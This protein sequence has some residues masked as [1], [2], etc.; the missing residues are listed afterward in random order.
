MTVGWLAGYALSGAACGAA[1]STLT[2]SFLPKQSG[3]VL[4]SW[5]LAAAVTGGALVIL[6]WRVGPRWELAPYWLLVLLGVPLAFIDLADRRLPRLLVH[7]LLLG[8]LGA[9]AMLCL[10]RDDA[11]PGIRGVA[12][13]AALS[14]VFLV[15]ALIVPGGIGAGDVRLAAVAGLVAGWSGW[16]SVLGTLLAS[17]AYAALLLGLLR[18]RRERQGQ[19][20]TAVP[21]GPC[22][23]AGVV[24]VV[25]VSG[26]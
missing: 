13:M 22:L 1:L 2:R 20:T 19:D 9:L 21:F 24:T 8:I 10:V 7:P 25:A 17:L 4:G 5:W 6:G 18:L 3:R 11:G 23:L 15:V 16:L 12:A 26:G 14:G